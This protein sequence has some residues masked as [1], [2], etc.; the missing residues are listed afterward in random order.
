MPQIRGTEKDTTPSIHNLADL[1][2]SLHKLIRI[3]IPNTSTR[4]STI[5]GQILQD[6]RTIRSDHTIHAYSTAP[7]RARRDSQEVVWGVHIQRCKRKH[8][9]SLIC[10]KCQSPF[11]NTHILGGCRFT[12]KLRIKRHNT[13]FRLLL[14]QLQKYNGGRWPILCADLGHKPDTDFRD[15]TTDMDTPPHTQHHDIKHPTQESL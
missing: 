10:T 2:S 4:H 14:Q 8:S 7:C 3:H 6:A 11:T 1:H 15:L 12:A 5:Y 13:T 9:P